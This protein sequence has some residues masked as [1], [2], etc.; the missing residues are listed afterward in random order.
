M[1]NALIFHFLYI[2]V[3]TLAV[4]FTLSVQCLMFLLN[5]KTFINVYYNCGTH[6]I[7]VHYYR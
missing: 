1:G 6:S 4:I 2:N 7:T 5:K 3:L